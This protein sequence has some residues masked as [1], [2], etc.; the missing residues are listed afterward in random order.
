MTRTTL[1]DVAREAGV[2]VALVSIVMRDAPGASAATRERV[3]GVAER[4]GYVPDQ[5]ARQLRRTD[6]RLLGVTFDLHQPFHGDLVEHLYEAA[7]AQGYDVAI[8]AVAPSRD[9]DAAIQALMRE[10]CDALVLLGPDLSPDAL[11]SL[12]TRVP[13]LV[14]ARRSDADG[15]ASVRGDDEAGVGLAVDHLADLGHVR[16]VHVD[17]GSAPGA[18]DRRRGFHAA[19]VRRGMEPWV[20]PGGPTEQAGVEAARRLLDQRPTPTAVV[21]FNDHCASGVLDVLLRAHVDVPA[22][23]SVVG[24]DDSRLAVARQD[25]MT[26]VAQS[27]LEMAERAVSGALD[28]LAGRNPTEVV[29]TPRLVVRSTSG[30]APRLADPA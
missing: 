11:G 22:D 19:A 17:G 18:E 21:A 20:V 24:Y 16:V 8:S 7:A 13:T 14:V 3:R 1:A 15:V 10:R 4:L 12:G 5:R 29:L 2:S 6:T 30:P 28:L 25:R 27:A 9:E 26:T 23:V